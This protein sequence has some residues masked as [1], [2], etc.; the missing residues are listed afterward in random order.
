MRRVA[1]ELGVTQPVLYSAFESR[2]ALIDAVAMAGF[3]AISEALE[4]V[5]PQPRLRMSA[6]LDFAR[7]NPRV[8]EAM[9]S[10]PSGLSFG[11]EDGPKTLRRAF[12]AIHEAFPGTHG[13]EAEVAWATVHGLATLQNSGRLPAPGATARLDYA[14]AALASQSGQ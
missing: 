8:Y 1:T 14:H 11:T 13:T 5:D 9:F 2:Q 3:A 12:A 10:L 4:A 6:Y 7:R